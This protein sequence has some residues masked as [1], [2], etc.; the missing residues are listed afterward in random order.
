MACRHVKEI[1]DVKP[2]GKGLHGVFEDGVGIG[3]ICACA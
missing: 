3:C 2:S 1:Q